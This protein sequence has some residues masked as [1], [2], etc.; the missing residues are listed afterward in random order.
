MNVTHHLARILLLIAL[1]AGFLGW[2]AKGAAILFNDG[3]RY[4]GQAQSLEAGYLHDGLVKS[5]D[6]PLYPIGI[7]VCHVLLG[8]EGAGGWQ[9]AAQAAS[10]LAALL[11]IIPLY[12]V[13]CE[14]FSPE[15]AWLG[16]L[17]AFMVP[18]TGTTMADTLSESTFLLFF[19][20]G[21][22]TSLRFL[23]EGTFIWL[24]PTILLSGLAYG[25]RPEGLV[26]PAALVATLFATPILR[27]TRM[28]WPR[29][30]A[31]VAFLVLGPALLVAPYIALKGGVGTKPAVSRLLGLSGK[32]PA[33]AVERERPLEPGQTELRTYVLAV[34]AM[35][36]AVKDAVT[37]PM[38]PLVLFGLACVWPPG[39]RARPWLFM[40]I[41]L[42]ASALAL[43]RLHATAGYCTD[44]HAMIIA[45]PLI[46]AAAH[47]LRILMSKLTIPGKWVGLED[48][49]YSAG[50]L[51]WGLLFLGLIF[52]YRSD[53]TTPIN[54][55]FLGYRL[56]S[57]FV[58]QK[59]DPGSRVVDLTGWT[60]YY[61]G[62]PGYTFA[63]V[64]QTP[65]DPDLRWVVVRD[66]HLVG[67]WEYCE[68]I[69]RIV[70]DRKPVATFPE[71]PIRRQ[72]HVYVYD[73]KAD[74][75][76]AATPPGVTRR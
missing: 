59:A 66:A 35:G 65:Q 60:Q 44:R 14:L 23:R 67:P 30:W 18:L 53:I 55:R 37:I 38:I 4:I 54:D 13:A 71:T 41:L 25:T 39:E 12:L 52:L 73:L 64:N 11:W 74:T 45:Y 33:S 22:W 47:G 1:A 76:Q 5:V 15:S 50:P 3:L 16:V 26:L 29:W 61:A 69:R 34:R 42:G 46:L 51:V 19:T 63:T 40:T 7:A 75:A 21:L 36:R 27:S 57:D 24:P 20:W 56:A 48:G 17:L 32:A 28:N 70:K 31:A 8:T 68:L 72:S 58:G 62:H 43:V 9:S 10:I 49:R 2:K 6:H